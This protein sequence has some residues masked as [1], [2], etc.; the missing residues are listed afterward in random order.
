MAE[1]NKKKPSM[2]KISE[3]QRFKYVGFEV[4]PGRIKNQFKSE[5]EKKSFIERL[6]M[7]RENKGPLGVLR[8][9]CTLLEPRVSTSDR[10]VLAIA[11]VMMVFALFLPWYSAY[12]EDIEETQVKVAAEVPDS[13]MANDSLVID[14]AALAAIGGDA[15]YT[16]SPKEEVLH[17]YVARKKITKNYT[18]LTGLGSLA[19]LG[20]VGGP[21]F[22]S[23]IILV[24]TGL[25]LLIMTLASILLPA[26]TLF[27]LF[28]LKGTPDQQALKLKSILKLN[29]LPLV[30][31]T[32]ALMASFVGANY[33]FD[34][35]SLYN[36]LGESYGPGV[37]LESL[38]WGV[39]VTLAA[40]IMLAAKGIE[41]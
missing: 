29:W 40:S 3:G 41:I 33:G 9:D 22:S 36:S 21:V 27:G 4:H 30:V 17:G 28:G 26:Y 20:S 31:F 24:L 8:D 12:N 18:R 25:I 1:D 19:A 5:A 15:G 37:L 6:R 16:D 38:S 7:K 2:K 13:T 23:G 34:A 32:V 35:V 14:S 39:L 11:C 10:I